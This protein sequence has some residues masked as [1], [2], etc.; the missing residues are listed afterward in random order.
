MFNPKPPETTPDSVKSVPATLTLL[1]AAKTTSP[2]RLQLSVVAARV[3]PC[4]VT[5]SAPT[6][7][8]FRSSTAPVATLTP[9]AVEPRPA[10]WLST[11][12]PALT[13]VAPL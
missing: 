3:P 7:I 9:E 5:V 11:S 2:A 8:P 1:F 12:V 6:A 4:K 13:T 10:A